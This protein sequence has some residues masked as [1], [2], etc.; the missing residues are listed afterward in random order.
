[1]PVNISEP[2]DIKD[3]MCLSRD[4][5]TNYIRAQDIVTI[6]L[7]ERQE[8]AE[9]LAVIMGENPSWTRSK[10][11]RAAVRRMADEIRERKVTMTKFTVV[12]DVGAGTARIIS[13][14]NERQ[15]HE[16]FVGE[17]DT[18]ALAEAEL[19]ELA[20][21]DIFVVWWNAG[22]AKGRVTVEN[23]LSG[24]WRGSGGV[25]FA[26]ICGEYDT[27]GKAD[28]KLEQVCMAARVDLRAA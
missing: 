4:G 24:N 21:P 2:V 18:K 8:Y 11:H 7:D 1:M 9:N 26:T 17:Y 20:G 14:G 19:S 27:H 16:T 22:D 5:R 25:P 13:P 10:T 12:Q 3:Y 6:P 28:A 23:K 15:F